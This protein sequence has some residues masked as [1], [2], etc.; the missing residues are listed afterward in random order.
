VNSN[1]DTSNTEG[2]YAGWICVNE[3]GVT[4]KENLKPFGKIE[5]WE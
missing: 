4:P 3:N 5:E 1:P 2:K